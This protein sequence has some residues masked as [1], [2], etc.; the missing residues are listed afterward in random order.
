MATD[1]DIREAF[2]TFDTDNDGLIPVG[3]IGTLIRA[4]GKAPLQSEV[5]A[6]E[7]EAGDTS[8]DLPTFKKYFERKFK[9]PSQLRDDMIKAFRALDNVGNGTI[10]EAELRVLLLSLIHI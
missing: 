10:T 9:V 6:I 1:K 5:D 7:K 4:L 2:Q 8:V 3:D